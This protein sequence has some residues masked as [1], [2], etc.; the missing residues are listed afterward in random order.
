MYMA[1]RAPELFPGARL[2]VA[3]CNFSLRGEESDAD[4]AFVREWCSG[5]GIECHTVRFD[6]ESYA[7]ERGISIEMAARELR[8]NWFAELRREYGYDAVAVAH[9]ANDNAET[10]ILNLLRGTGSRGIRGMGDRDGIVRPLLGTTREQIREWM[11]ERGIPWREDRTNA[12]SSY[13][14]NLIRNEVFPLFGRIN[15]SFIRTLN[16]DMA[17][18][19]QADDIAEDYFLSVRDTVKD[20][21]GSIFTERL[22]S[23]RHWEF[24]LW[25][26][27]ED[28]GIGQEEFNSLVSTLR[29]GRQ[30]AGRSFGPVT[31][32]HKRIVTVRRQNSRELH[33]EIVERGEI[34]SLKQPQGILVADADTLPMPPVVRRW[35]NGD[36]MVPYGMKGRKKISDMLTD[37]KYTRQEKEE[38]EVIELNGSH[39][40]ALLCRRIDDSVKITGSTEKVAV[41]RYFNMN[42]SS[43]GS[44]K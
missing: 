32:A 20:T 33:W 43:S 28:T 44:E 35:R 38:A 34:G 23:L 5:K 14:R 3:H 8:Y 15:P 18:F 17:R 7:S 36:W 13:R 16:A 25:R 41:F 29:S 30:Y 21:D 12:D 42:T 4:E 31:G 2:A 37:L 39:V 19:A 9:N 40:A 10:L 24:V 22:L 11:C 6:T 26:L 1:N 27:L